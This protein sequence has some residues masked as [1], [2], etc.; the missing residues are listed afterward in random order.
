MNKVLMWIKSVRLT[1]QTLKIATLLQKIFWNILQ[2]AANIRKIY[3]RL[4]QLCA[5]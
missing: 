4:Q 1:G 3:W 5:A 2:A